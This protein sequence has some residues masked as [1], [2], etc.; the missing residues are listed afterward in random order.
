MLAAFGSYSWLKTC[1][2]VDEDV[3][4]FDIRDVWWA[5]S[6]RSRPDKGTLVIPAAVRFPRD[7][8]RIHQSKLGIDATIPLGKW[9]EFERITIPG[10]EVKPSC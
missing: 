8:Y 9:E 5:I 3:D 7:L 10:E 2:A 4:A 6:T 1:I